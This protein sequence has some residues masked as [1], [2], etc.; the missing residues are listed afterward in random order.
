MPI[1]FPPVEAIAKSLQ[2]LN[3]SPDDIPNPIDCYCCD[4]PTR[5]AVISYEYEF[6]FEPGITVTVSKLMPGYRCAE[7]I[8]FFD[9]GMHN[10]FLHVI[11]DEMTFVG[12]DSL[13]RLLDCELPRNIVFSPIPQAIQNLL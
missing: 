3:P 8:D 1:E 12:D 4:K 10:R 13:Q 2:S 11:A 5:K 6:K 9:S 7:D